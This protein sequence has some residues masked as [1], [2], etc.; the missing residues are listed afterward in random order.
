MRAAAI[1]KSLRWENLSFH[2]TKSAETDGDFLPSSIAITHGKT[3][4]RLLNTL[5]YGYYS[6]VPTIPRALRLLGFCSVELVHEML[7][8]GLAVGRD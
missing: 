2:R 8:S 3:A 5:H 4:L 6:T 7:D 1:L